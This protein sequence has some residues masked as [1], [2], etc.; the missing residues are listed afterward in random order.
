MSNH[1]H[2][3]KRSSD[4]P[5]QHPDAP[6]D[7]RD[8]LD[9]IK[10]I[11]NSPSYKIAIDDS[12]FL[13]S[14]EATPMRLGLDYHKAE[15]ILKRYGILK[16]IVVYGSTRVVDSKRA[17]ERLEAIKARADRSKD[18]I[19]LQKELKR[20]ESI[21]EKSKYYDDAR[22]FGKIVAECGK[23]VDDNRLVLMT[24]GGPGIMEAANRG[25]YDV[26]ANSIGL[27][28]TL[29]HE[30]FPNPYI[31]PDLCF[32]FYYFATRKIHFMKRAAALVVYPGGFGTLDEVFEALTLIQTTKLDPIPVI[33]V[34]S[35]Y[36]RKVINFEMLEEEGV[37][38]SDDLELFC[39]V[40]SAKEA[41]D[42][43]KSYYKDSK[44]DL[45]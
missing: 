30:Q 42:E 35:E 25:A 13:N 16:T 44:L 17:K 29:P 34:G 19:E 14:T 38:S 1:K 2:R 12:L 20:A 31:T 43:I 6:K 22:E 39:F 15:S 26:G 45:F 9:N 10:K 4:L 8:A 7:D 33:F 5:W 28:I 24:G 40:D 18:D 32:L 41:W 11:M 23:G 37:I 3:L 21:L 27:N 36:W